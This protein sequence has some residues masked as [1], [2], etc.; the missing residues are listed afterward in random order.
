MIKNIPKNSETI[1]KIIVEILLVIMKLLSLLGTILAAFLSFAFRPIIWLANFIFLKLFA[2]V[3]LSFFSFAKKIGWNR[4]RG[5]FLSF[6]LSR[7]TVH[8]LMAC[9]VVVISV[10]GLIGKT[11]NAKPAFD[12]AGK[13][14]IAGLV[15]REFVDSEE[16]LIEEF[17]DKSASGPK[18]G[19]KYLDDSLATANKMR[20]ATSTEEEETV[21]ADLGGSSGEA[22]VK[23]EVATTK[24]SKKTRKTS[25]EYFVA[26]G[27]SISTIAA[28]F[29][30]SVN[31]ILW[32]NNLSAYSLIRPG[33]KLVILP[34][35]GITY[36][37]AKGETLGAIAG[38]SGVEAE[39]IIAAN[40]LSEDSK[41]AAGQSLFIPGGK[42]YYY[43]APSARVAQSYN[44][45]QVI[46]DLIKPTNIPANRMFWPTVGHIITQYF[47]WRHGGLDIA[48]KIGTPVYAADSGT[49][50]DAG[51]SKAG[52]GNKIDIDH[53][54]GK[55]TR[56]G[57]SSKLL[58]KKG[59]V[60][61]KGDIIMLMGSTGKSTGPHLHFEVRINGR[62][63]N[64]LS[65]IR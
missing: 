14:I 23:P 32:E 38:K 63:Q 29:D 49:V 20:I 12:S 44:P 17:A 30:I 19:I 43:A 50:I 9:L 40:N 56:Y 35:T 5:N 48:N 46:K 13:T 11:T 31:T 51:W 15:N 65:Y 47:S 3:Y 57:H 55:V 25:I 52:Y 54:G 45:I 2:K 4:L 61:N 16:E 28:E 27:D 41:L 60:V 1:K 6:L 58:V 22:L 7:K 59:D 10:S 62:V 33:D 34:S 36:K 18:S 37:V 8:I 39:A 53:G 64:P 24:K 21:L 42:K 26:P